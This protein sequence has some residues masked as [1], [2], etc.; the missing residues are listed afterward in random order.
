MV[1]LSF[2]RPTTLRDRAFEAAITAAMGFFPDVLRIQF[3]HTGF[4]TSTYESLIPR[5]L[6]GGP[7]WSRGEAELIASYVSSLNHCLF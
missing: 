7:D 2:L 6:R 5:W 1:R 3:A 4:P